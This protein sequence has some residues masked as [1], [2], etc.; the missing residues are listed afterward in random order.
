MT[1]RLDKTANDINKPTQQ[2]VKKGGE[3]VSTV[4]DLATDER[5][6]RMLLEQM[7]STSRER[8][9]D[10][11]KAYEKAVDALSTAVEKTAEGVVD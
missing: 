11:K 5:K 7:K 10:A 3:V 1:A 9:D 6:A 2:A 4:S 8:W